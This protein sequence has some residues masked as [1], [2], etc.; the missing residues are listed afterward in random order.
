MSGEKSEETGLDRPDIDKEEIEADFQSV[1]RE[2]LQSDAE[3]DRPL[4]P[5]QAEAEPIERGEV[6]E[7][8]T[9]AAE[10]AESGLGAGDDEMRDYFDVMSNLRNAVETQSAGSS[11]VGDESRTCP[12][13]QKHFRYPYLLK[14]HSIAHTDAKPNSCPYCSFRCKWRSTM[15]YHISRFHSEGTPGQL[16]ETNQDRG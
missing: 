16:S 7:L 4:N 9:S 5:E 1:L 10:G 11:T 3:L 6:E 12:V 13:C 15:K 8:L 14:I 2:V